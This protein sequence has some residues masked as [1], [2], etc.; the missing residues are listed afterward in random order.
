[1]PEQVVDGPGCRRSVRPGQQ[2]LP[3]VEDHAPK[4]AAR[5]AMAGR[6]VERPSACV[7][8][9][10]GLGRL[11]PSMP[12]PHSIASTLRACQVAT[13]SSPATSA[14]DEADRRLDAGDYRRT[15][16]EADRQSPRLRR[17]PASRETS[18]RPKRPPER[19]CNVKPAAG[20]SGSPFEGQ[21]GWPRRS[22]ASS[23]ASTAANVARFHAFGVPPGQV[24]CSLAELLASGQR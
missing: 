3:R 21:T 10:D 19:P 15:G 9:L 23:T 17:F 11:R 6:S 18:G 4:S 1:M 7:E 22:S 14:R 20:S 12:K 16:C 24:G 13:G 2:R 5:L 8:Q